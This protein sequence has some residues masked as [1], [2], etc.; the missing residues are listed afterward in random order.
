MTALLHFIG[1]CILATMGVGAI[2][3]LSKAMK[4]GL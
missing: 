3:V 4:E 2:I 1:W